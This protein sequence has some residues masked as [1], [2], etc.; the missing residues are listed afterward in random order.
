MLIPIGFIVYLND[1]SLPV[2]KLEKFLGEK[3]LY[4][5]LT[6]DPHP[7]D[8]TI[9]SGGFIASVAQREDVEL[10]HICIT[11]GEKGDEL[12]KIS[13][14]ELANVRKD[15]LEQALKYLGV[16]KYEIWNYPDGGL[17]SREKELRNHLEKK[18]RHLKPDLILVYEKSGIYGHT[19]HVVLSQVAT[20]I[21]KDLNIKV[22]YKTISP[23]MV[24]YAKLPKHIIDKVEDVAVPYY[25]YP[26]MTKIWRKYKA[27]K[28]H[29][30]QNLTHG[31]PLFLKV[32]VCVN[33]YYT[34]KY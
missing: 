31:T 21:V 14:N 24:N 17:K 4:K 20:E 26:V 8:E 18:I 27:A 2:F 13:E 25:R 12:L 11:H 16:K 23:K 7:D 19:D 5:I 29:K 34:D 9:L 28:S 6:I 22:L 33:E 1:F 3:E 30:S 10:T 15:E 32:L